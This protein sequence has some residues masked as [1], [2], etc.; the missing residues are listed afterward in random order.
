M[1]LRDIASLIDHSL[2]HPTLDDTGIRQGCAV[3]RACQVRTVCVKPYAIALARESL[4]GCSVS[5]C[6]VVGFPHGSSMTETKLRETQAAIAAGAT[7]IDMVV[8]IGKVLG[9]QYDYVKEEIRIVNRAVLRQ[10]AALKVIFENAFLN[11]TQIIALCGICADARAAF[12]KTSTGFAFLPQP[13][14]SFQC[15]GARED[16]VLLMRR[17][18]PSCVQVKAA[19]GIRTLDAVLKFHEL[20]CTR[21]GLSATESILREAAQR[22]FV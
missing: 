20:G 4:K 6:A 15:S 9:G 1:T 22:G 13:D 7:E 2:L 11:E 10:G 17:H 12:V 14:G 19:G 5:I 21:V 8:N 3:A 18:A 16:Q